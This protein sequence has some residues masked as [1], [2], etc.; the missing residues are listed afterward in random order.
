VRRCA[1][2][3]ERQLAVERGWRCCDRS[4][5]R[6]PY[7][8]RNASLYAWLTFLQFDYCS[9][10]EGKKD[11]GNQKDP[12]KAP[13]SCSLKAASSSAVAAARL[14]LLLP[15]HLNFRVEAIEKLSKSRART[16]AKATGSL[17]RRL[18]VGPGKVGLRRGVVSHS[19]TTQGDHSATHVGSV[20]LLE[21]HRSEGGRFRSVRKTLPLESGPNLFGRLSAYV[22]VA[23][24]DES[25]F[26]V[27]SRTCTWLTARSRRRSS[28]SVRCRNLR[29]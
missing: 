23:R 2:T 10:Q 6:T 13:R 4:L 11:R 21:L 18:R 20:V 22:S 5:I 27:R 28:R 1:A 25:E 15:D 26:R 19:L 8:T 29:R 9:A 24:S 7:T 12:K 3:S 14:K 16:P 17:R